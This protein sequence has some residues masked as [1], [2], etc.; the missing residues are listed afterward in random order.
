M[1][2]H[3]QLIKG[4]QVFVFDWDGT[5]FDSMPTKEANFGEAF[6]VAL[7]PIEGQPVSPEVVSGL[8][9]KLS[10]LSREEIF[11]SILET[12]DINPDSGS[13]SRFDK[14]FTRLNRSR[15]AEALL[16]PD[17]IEIIESLKKQK[18]TVYISS[19][20]PQN[21]LDELVTTTLPE[22]LKLVFSG[23]L[24]SSPGFHKGP[25]HI[26][27]ILKKEHCQREKIL[28]IGNDLMD[29]KLSVKAS[30]HCILVN[31]NHQI[32]DGL[33]IPMIDSLSTFHTQVS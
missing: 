22:E 15:L 10:G 5:L 1:N 6:L 30:V 32:Q 33:D 21:E 20:V 7:N 13:Y 26:E 16:F 18:K 4:K 11:H 23:V 14:E 3:E 2:Q 28:F 9:R 12:L 17:G 25:E 31:R 27:F 8:Y 19:S 29:Y 24:G